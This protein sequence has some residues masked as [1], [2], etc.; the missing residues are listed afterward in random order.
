M[1]SDPA[2]Y[3]HEGRT[4]WRPDDQLTHLVISLAFYARIAL[5]LLGM[6]FLDLVERRIKMLSK[7]DRREVT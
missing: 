5:T 4:I 3:N 1:Q 6:A 7:P 2:D